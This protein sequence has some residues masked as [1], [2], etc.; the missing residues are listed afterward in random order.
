[1]VEH[2]EVRFASL[3]LVVGKT[4]TEIR[5]EP[6]NGAPA[7]FN[8]WIREHST[9]GPPINGEAGMSRAEVIDYLKSWDVER[10]RAN[11]LMVLARDV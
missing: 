1:M 4:F 11:A 10:H 7:L 9:D 2:R 3:A 8:V 5:V 6:V